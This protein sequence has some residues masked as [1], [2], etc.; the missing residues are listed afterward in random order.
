MRSRMYRQAARLWA[1]DLCSHGLLDV[2]GGGTVAA[3]P[4]LHFPVA[5]RLDACCSPLR[6]VPRENWEK[7]W[8]K[9]L[10]PR[11]VGARPANHTRPYFTRPR[12]TDVDCRSRRVETDEKSA[13]PGFMSYGTS[14]AEENMVDPDVQGVIDHQC[15]TVCDGAQTESQSCYLGSMVWVAH[16]LRRKVVVGQ[17][18]PSP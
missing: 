7:S 3:P 1:L 17:L 10:A 9:R 2:A 14:I 4:P 16:D 15:V 12:V 13:T 18:G 5:R 6:Q 8:D 11:T